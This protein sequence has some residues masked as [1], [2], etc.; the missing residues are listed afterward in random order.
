MVPMPGRNV[1]ITFKQVV[2]V[3]THRDRFRDIRTTLQALYAIYDNAAIRCTPMHISRPLP[4]L[5]KRAQ[6]MAIRLSS[7]KKLGHSQERESGQAFIIEELTDLVEAAVLMEF[8][9]SHRAR[10]CFGCDGNHVPAKQDSRGK[11]VLR[12]PEAHRRIPDY[13]REHLPKSNEV[14]QQYCQ[15][16]LSV[17][18]KR[19]SSI[20]VACWRTSTKAR[21]N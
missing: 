2:A 11:S 8:R 5:R 12:D 1:S 7:I 4:R 6:A 19:K 17:L 10:W 18:R 20:G 15:W 16:K 21:K 3:C 14:R 13:W 9:P